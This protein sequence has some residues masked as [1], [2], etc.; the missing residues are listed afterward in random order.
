[1]AAGCFSHKLSDL[2]EAGAPGNL[3]GWRTAQFSGSRRLSSDAEECLQLGEHECPGLVS[4][5]I[6]GWALHMAWM[7]PSLM[8]CLNIP[9]LLTESLGVKLS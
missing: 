1:M 8:E 4:W 5:G 6:V 2:E 9:D 7:R 3:H